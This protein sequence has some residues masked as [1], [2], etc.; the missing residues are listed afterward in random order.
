MSPRGSSSGSDEERPW[1]TILIEDQTL[2]L[3]VLSKTIDLNTKFDLLAAVGDGTTG[4]RLCLEQTPDLLVTDIRL[5]DIDGLDVAKEVI[6]CAPQVRILALTNL[7]DPFTLNRLQEIGVHGYVEKDQPLEILEEAMEEVAS[8]RTYF[9]AVLKQCWDRLDQSSES[10][11]KFLSQREQQI[12]AMVAEGL[13]SAGIAERL[14][15]SKRSVETYRY[16]IMKRL[17]IT[18]TAGLI[19]YFHEQSEQRW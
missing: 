15:L 6:R 8:G 14:D 12:V 19:R 17:G 11:T 2:L 3:N 5:P 10:F 9:T 1:R 4:K 18:S 13:S 16:R 7:K